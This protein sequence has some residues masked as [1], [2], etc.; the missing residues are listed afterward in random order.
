MK[1]IILLSMIMSVSIYAEVST[2]IDKQK[3]EKIKQIQK[4]Y[5]NKLRKKCRYSSAYFAQQHTQNEWSHFNTQG[6][7]KDEFEL[8]CPRGK[9][10]LDNNEMKALYF[11]A[12]E[13]AEDTKKYPKT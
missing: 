13:Y 9:N 8:L 5:K 7:F 6:Q 3:S 4:T 11:F 2:P 12:K 10:V 1:T